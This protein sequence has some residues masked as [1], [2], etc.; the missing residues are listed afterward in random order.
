[1]PVFSPD[2]SRIAFMSMR[3]GNSEL[4]VM[5]RD[6]SGVRRLTNNPAIDI[7]PTWSPTGTRS[8]SRPIDRDRRR[9][10]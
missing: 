7:T 6:G 5:N 10:G 4:Y 9:S 1:M 8:R 3:D 2:G